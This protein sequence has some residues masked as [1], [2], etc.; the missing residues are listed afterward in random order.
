[1]VSSKRSLLPLTRRPAFTP[2]LWV[3]LTAIVLLPACTSIR[4]EPAVDSRPIGPIVRIIADWDDLDA[5]VDVAA[6]ANQLALV[7]RVDV[8]PWHAEFYLISVV[9][10][11]VLITARAAEPPDRHDSSARDPSDPSEQEPR[12]RW[13]QSVA[14]DLTCRYGHGGDAA[15][16]STILRAVARRLAQLH[17]RDYAP[18]NARE[19]SPRGRP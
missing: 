12:T 13:G 3:F 4:F 15:R 2:A 1:M 18:L 7:R 17:S 19:N 16:D 9:E 14:I 11:P 8:S 5:A 10:K 6:G